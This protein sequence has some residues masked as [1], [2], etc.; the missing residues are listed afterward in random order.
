MGA[1]GWL[2]PLSI[3]LLI[4]A[5][6]RISQFMSSSPALGSVLAVQSLLGILSLPAPPLLHTL[7]LSL[8]INLR[9]REKMCLRQS[10][11]EKAKGASELNTSV[12]YMK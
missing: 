5:Q 1:P 11:F 4:S 6:V 10:G 3:Q 2:S 9:K 12:I 8:Q 7:S